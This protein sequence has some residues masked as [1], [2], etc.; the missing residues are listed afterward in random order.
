MDNEAIISQVDGIFRD[1]LE[2]RGF[3]LIDLT[4]RFENGRNV[5]R[6]LVDLPTGGITIRECAELNRELGTL[7][8]GKD[9][10]P[11]EYDLEVNSPGLDRPLRTER[12][13]ARNKGKQIKVFLSEEI[14]G[15]I[16]VDGAVNEVSA[17]EVTLMTRDGFA[18]I[19]FNKINKAKILI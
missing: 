14:N 19:P 13:F 16:E 11:A 10:I 9:I 3:E 12:D 5:L 2:T 1:Y 17:E 18:S 8:E 6:A 4:Y 7:L 15:K